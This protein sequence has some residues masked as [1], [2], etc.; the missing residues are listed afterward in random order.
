MTKPPRA[1]VSPGV[2]VIAGGAGDDSVG[3]ELPQALISELGDDQGNPL[4]NVTVQL[5]TSNPAF[6][7]L[8]DLTTPVGVGYPTLSRAT[9]GQGRIALLVTMGSKTGTATV[10][11]TVPSTG[12]KATATYTIRPGM[13]AKVAVQPKDTSAYVGKNL[14]LHAVVEDRNGNRRTEAPTFDFGN[15]P[16]VLSGS[17]S[18]VRPAHI[19]RGFVVARYGTVKTDTA[20]V[21][22]VPTGTITA[23]EYA[24]FE[25]NGSGPHPARIITMQLDGS[26]Y[27]AVLTRDSATIASQGGDYTNGMQPQ[28]SPAGNEIAYIYQQ[29]LCAIDL[30]G[31]TRVISPDS[32]RVS[33]RWAPQYS[34]DG[35][36]SYVTAQ[37]SDLWRLRADGS[38]VERIPSGIYA[39][40]ALS[41]SPGNDSV[42]F[43]S[44]PPGALNMV[45]LTIHALLPFQ[46]SGFSPRW[47]PTGDRIA[48]LDG[49]LPT[50]LYIVLPDGT[51]RH[52]IGPGYAAHAN[53]GWSPDGHWLI[54]S[55]QQPIRGTD[56]VTVGL[57]LLNVDTGMR[58]PLHSSHPMLQPSWKQ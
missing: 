21:S 36:W 12:A 35:Q 43:G 5:A 24:Y 51:Q 13:P 44:D 26:D 39:P 17:D 32:V 20:W 33:D 30:N 56:F 19:G 28:W 25:A 58:L 53:Y 57:Y 16:T 49:V 11:I 45:D 46:I 27:R 3:A 34:A 50:L 7:L 48:L 54:L 1:S 47:S 40:A 18:T 15:S 10:T 42:V 55:A 6:V 14:V 8:S 38:A 23:Y 31:H 37:N 52:L 2:H 29:H 41:P 4:P 22:V 9:D